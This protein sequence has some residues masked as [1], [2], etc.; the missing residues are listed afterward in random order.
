MSDRACRT[1]VSERSLAWAVLLSMLTGAAISAAL[2]VTLAAPNSSEDAAA[3]A[4]EAEQE[5][6]WGHHRREAPE[7]IAKCAG[8]L[9]RIHEALRAFDRAHG[10]PLVETERTTLLPVRIVRYLNDKDD[11]ICPAD[12]TK[13]THDGTEEHPTSYSYLYSR[14]WLEKNGGRYIPLS[15]DSAIVVCDHHPGVVMVLRWNGVV[16]VAPK[17]K[18]PEGF[19]VRFARAGALRQTD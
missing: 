18:Y 16:E 3:K 13:G 12:P 14:Y 6:V 2:I 4:Y 17:G 5:R 7:S 9:S 1:A 19:F 8:Q 10:R 11:L 15:A